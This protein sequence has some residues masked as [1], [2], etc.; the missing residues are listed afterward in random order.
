MRS[1]WPCLLMLIFIFPLDAVGQLIGGMSE[2][3]GKRW[4]IRFVLDGSPFPV[5]MQHSESYRGEYYRPGSQDWEWQEWDSL[6]RYNFQD[7]WF[8]NVRL[9]AQLNVIHNLYL[10]VNYSAYL[11]QRYEQVSP[12]YAYLQQFPFV[13]LS[14]SL[15]YPFHLPFAPRLEILPT[16]SA[17]NYQSDSYQGYEGL[18]Q[19]WAYEGRLGVGIQLKGN[20]L[21]QIRFWTASHHFAYRE[22]NLSWVYPERIREVRTDWQFVNFGLGL[23]WHLQIDEN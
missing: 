11:V 22:S 15:S 9:G 4:N 5:K 13:S 6:R 10:G 1:L 18:G 8:F 23:V 3:G 2:N 14:A 7:N 17:G 16:V 21:Q 12:E 20:Y 19:E